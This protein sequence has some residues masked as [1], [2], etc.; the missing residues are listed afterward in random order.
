MSNKTETKPDAAKVPATPSLHEVLAAAAVTVADSHK[1]TINV[2]KPLANGRIRL[3]I[4]TGKAP[5]PG[6]AM[7][8]ALDV[9]SEAGG[10]HTPSCLAA[11]YDSVT[12]WLRPL[13]QEA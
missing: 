12:V 7:G 4:M 10:T 6:M 3:D 1:G 5:D 8:I 13:K 2:R 9:C 11:G